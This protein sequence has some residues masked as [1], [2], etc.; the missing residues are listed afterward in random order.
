MSKM[1]LFQQ[2]LLAVIIIMVI[3]G[4]VLTAT[5]QQ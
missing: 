3:V 1:S 4:I 2:F 5:G